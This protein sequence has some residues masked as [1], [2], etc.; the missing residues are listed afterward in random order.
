MESI[1]N[2]NASPVSAR[3]AVA[4]LRLI[5]ATFPALLRDPGN[6]DLRRDMTEASLC[7]VLAFSNRKAAI[8]HILSYPITLGWG[9]Q[10]GITCS[11]TLPTILRSLR[12]RLR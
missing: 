1:R 3:H 9:V 4:A 6:L 5:I 11:F 8:A 10:H 2:V 7:A 12:G